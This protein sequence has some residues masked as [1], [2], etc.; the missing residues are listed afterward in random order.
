MTRR[1]EAY[2]SRHRAGGI[3]LPE[4]LKPY[5]IDYDII[6][7]DGILGARDLWP[8]HVGAT[9]GELAAEALLVGLGERP[10]EDEWETG[11]VRRNNR[12][13]RP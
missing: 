10:Y 6:E 5:D 11:K 13:R 9:P 4:S 1:G 2:G 8:P 7:C 12:R 3:R